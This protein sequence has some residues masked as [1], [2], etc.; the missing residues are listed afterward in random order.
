MTYHVC[1]AVGD[2]N[3][4][5]SLELRPRTLADHT[6]R[7]STNRVSSRV[8]TLVSDQQN[9]DAAARLCYSYIGS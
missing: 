6:A 7:R 2:L 9:M 4:F 5:R 1:N 3:S 8:K